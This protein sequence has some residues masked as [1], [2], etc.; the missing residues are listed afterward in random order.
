MR[1]LTILSLA[2]C[3]TSSVGSRGQAAAAP[4]ERSAK[5]FADAGPLARPRAMTF[6]YDPSPATLLLKSIGP[7]VPGAKRGDLQLVLI[8]YVPI[9]KGEKLV[10]E[11]VHIIASRINQIPAPVVTAWA[12]SARLEPLAAVLAIAADDDFFPAGKFNA[13]LVDLAMKNKRP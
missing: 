11:R 8:R 1:T 13:S 5:W 9:W 10:S 7:K 2:F 12:K 3:L 6:G 4:A